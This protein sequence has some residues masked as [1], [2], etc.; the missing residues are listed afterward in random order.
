M[1]FGSYD[2]S[3][4]EQPDEDEEEVD[5]EELMEINTQREEGKMTY[6]WKSEDDDS[7][8]DADLED[9]MQHLADPEDE[10]DE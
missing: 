4:Q 5:E 3:E 6:E 9:M 8:G 10:E 7:E 2:E 1:G